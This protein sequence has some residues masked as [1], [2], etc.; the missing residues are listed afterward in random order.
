MSGGLFDQVST[1]AIG[2]ATERRELDRYYTPDPLAAAL[3][4]LLPIRPLSVVIEPSVGGGA[5]VRA[6]RAHQPGATIVGVDL[7]PAARG[8]DLVDHAHVGSW[9]DI[10]DDVVRVAVGSRPFWVV[11][12]PPYS[13]ALEHV[14]AALPHADGVAF[15]LRLAF[16]EGV[17]RFERLWSHGHGTR[18]SDVYVLADRPSFTGSGTDATAYALFVWRAGR[19]GGAKVRPIRVVGGRVQQGLGCVP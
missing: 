3:V 9:P 16:L 13:E 12:N 1:H 17:A 19:V 15:L 11:G 5:W 7:D 8:L 14:E 4:T 6:V 18:L 2:P 10:A